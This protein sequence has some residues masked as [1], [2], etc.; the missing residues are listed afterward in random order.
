MGALASEP[1]PPQAE[2]WLSAHVSGY[3][4]P[5]R[6]TK[7]S[8]GQSN[9]TFRLESGGGDYVLRRK[10]LG[11]LLPKAHAIEREFRVLS[12]LEGTPV[13]TPSVFALCEDREILGAPFY[14]MELVVGRI[15]Y[16][17]R[18]PGLVADERRRLFDAMGEAV[19]NLHSAD[20]AVLGLG[21][22]GRGEGFIAR[23][24]GLW[25]HQ[26]RASETVPIDSMEQLIEWLPANLPAE[27]PARVF[28]GDLRLDNMIFH[29]SEPRVV[30]LLDWELSTL[31]DPL[32]DFAYHAMVWRV[33]ANLFRGFADLERRA[34]GIPEEEE[35]VRSYC[36]RTG[37]DGIPDWNFDL[38]FSLF[39]VAAILQGVRHRAQTGQASSTDAA[40]VGAKA[41]PLAD[42]GW[43]V[44]QGADSLAGTRASPVRGALF[45]QTGNPRFI[46]EAYRLLKEGIAFGRAFDLSSGGRHRARHL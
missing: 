36:Q 44:A 7:F 35:Y 3:R 41:G 19:A 6:L 30:G 38:A 8:F 12:A 46:Y 39:R 18:M 34:H 28:H 37:R 24:V 42:I 29:P 23:Q 13:P 17:Q 15:F 9:P 1:L 21:D 40:E 5:G 43:A 4:G 16:D 32:A 27:Q 22:Y 45:C 14:V 25:T 10:P 20:P 31:G 11:L 26:Y 33:G 2:A